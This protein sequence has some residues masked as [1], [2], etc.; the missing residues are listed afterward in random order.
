MSFQPVIPAGGNLGWIFLSRTREAQQA[1]HDQSSILAR[2]AQHFADRIGQINSAEDLVSDRQL[3]TVALGAFGLD[4]DINNKFFIKK[5]LEEGTAEDTA[6]ANRLADKRYFAMAEA[7]GFDL[8]PPNTVLS[9]FA[10]KIV[11]QFRDRQFEVAVGAQDENLRLALGLE[12]ELSNL[13]AR[14][15]SQDAAWYTIMGTPPLRHVFETA[16]GL[17]AAAGAIDVDKQLDIFREKSKKYFGTSDPLA[18]TDPDH[19]EELTRR[20]LVRADLGTASA[21]TSSGATALTL[22]S[23]IAPASIL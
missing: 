17:P 1:A 19:R 10:D 21:A 6:F 20:F 2:Q 4:D 5:V 9:D 15:L 8:S 22:L 14:D 13:A 18:F 12:R 7:F 3:L 11:S 16:L 23:S